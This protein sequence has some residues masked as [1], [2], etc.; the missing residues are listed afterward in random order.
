VTAPLVERSPT[1]GAGV[2]VRPERRT[3]MVSPLPP[4]AEPIPERRRNTL[5]SAVPPPAEVIGVPVA[6]PGE[7]SGEIRSRAGASGRVDSGAASIVVAED[8]A[9]PSPGE[10]VV[11]EQASV[12]QTGEVGELPPARPLPP[13]DGRRKT[14]RRR[15]NTQR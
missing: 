6:I 3:P 15:R 10:G 5:V 12:S 4:P 7:A 1:P 9:T 2:P 14:A 8:E 11:S 13:P